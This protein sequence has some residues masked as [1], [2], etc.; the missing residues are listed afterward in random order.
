MTRPPCSFPDC[1]RPNVA[2][3]LCDGHYWQHR[4]GRELKPLRRRVS[5]SASLTERLAAAS[6]PTAGGCIEW[7]GSR[8]KAGYGTMTVGGR[9]DFAHRVAYVDT[10]GPIEGGMVVNHICGNPP[11]INPDHLEQVTVAQNSQFRVAAYSKTG[12]RGVAKL[13][14]GRYSATAYA[15]GIHHYLGSFDTIEQAERGA[16]EGRRRLG[17][18][19]PTL[20]ETS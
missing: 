14:S 18:H 19:N 7:T 20:E 9:K 5:N 12:V 17:F 15:D 11:C 16:V 1:G 3:Q 6:R 10:Y 4:Q 13:P 2:R 8:S